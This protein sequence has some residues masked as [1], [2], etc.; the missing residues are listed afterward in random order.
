MLLTLLLVLLIL[1][2]IALGAVVLLQ[3]SEGG[4]LG[5]GGGPSGFMTARGAGDL[6]TRATWILG[7]LVFAL[8]LAL[9]ILQGRLHGGSVV[10]RLKIDPLNADTPTRLPVAP[11]TPAAPADAPTGFEAP[12]PQVNG[13]PA[14][15]FGPAA[16]PAPAPSAASARRA[17]A[18]AAPAAPAPSVSAT[19]APAPSGATQ[20]PP[21][22][23]T[24][25]VS[26]GVGAVGGLPAQ[27]TT[28]APKSNATGG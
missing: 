9:T 27:G 23:N 17:P 10:D 25:P 2:C 28:P 6:L 18:A 4:A 13:A 26:P 19:T 7:G 20:T 14:T 21:A 3:Q 5:M 11:A 24:G 22:T 15:G 1:V 16:A 8:C 12:A